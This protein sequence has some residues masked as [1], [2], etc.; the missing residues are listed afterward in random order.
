[1]SFL[2]VCPSVYPFDTERAVATM[3]PDLLK[4][5]RVIDNTQTNHGVAA[6]WNLGIHQVL[7]DRLDWLILMSS[8][9]RFG[10]A[11]GRD[12]IDQLTD[13][14]PTL[15]GGNGIGWHLVAF[16]RWH[17]DQVGS[18]DENFY[19]AY[20]EDNDYGYRGQVLGI[21]QAWP[22]AEIDAH[23]IGNARAARFAGIKVD[24]ARLRDY[25]CRKHG[26][27]S[28]LETYERPFGD[29]A[30]D[31]TWWP[32]PG[33][34]YALERP[35]AGNRLPVLIDV[36]AS[37]EAAA[38]QTH[39]GMVK[40]YEDVARY[41]AIL[42]ETKPEVIIECGTFSGKSAAW[43]AR[44]SQVITIDTTPYVDVQTLGDW[45]GRV[46]LVW[47]SSVD[48]DTVG[49][50]G[51]MAHDLRTMV[52]L[53]SDHSAAHVRAEME[54]YGPMVTPGCYMVVEDGLV[55]WMPDQDGYQG[56][57]LDAIEDFLAEHGDEWERDTVIEQMFP[58]SQFP[59]GWLRKR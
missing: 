22:K 45:D 13:D 5:T 32:E 24:S 8:S 11:G 1:V 14:K 10:A 38:R 54:A 29:G 4:H 20:W 21:D 16:P 58:Q 26:G 42:S 23:W 48:P 47:A 31:M 37:L 3:H 7:K 55:R 17:L 36:E 33:H 53:D 40:T 19:P 6:S 28:G 25:Y 18:F 46:E 49:K 50:V 35:P 27:P 59:A 2:I 9:M 12:F 43:F 56:S 39:L 30:Y 34:P 41:E 44:H 51:L 52:V 15:E 57:P